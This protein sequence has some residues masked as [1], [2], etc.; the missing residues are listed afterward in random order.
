MKI[1]K[2]IFKIVIFVAA[3]IAGTFPAYAVRIGTEA[4]NFTAKNV[5]GANVSL[6][7]FRGKIVVLDW[8]NYECPFIIKHYGSGN[9]PSL[10][11]EFTE[12]GVVWITI[13]SSAPDKQG[14]FLPEQLQEESKKANNFATYEIP[15]PEGIIGR[16]YEAKT[17]PHIYVIDEKGIVQYNGA[18]DSIRSTNVE[19]IAK[20]VPYARNAIEAVLS[21]AAY[22][23]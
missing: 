5:Y 20:A 12:K 11:K 9:I 4:P 1:L 17:T 8:S 19:D 16:L 18:I 2:P 23:T 14:Y 3:L 7:D 10:Q 15:D 22:V 21:G 13:H 6:S